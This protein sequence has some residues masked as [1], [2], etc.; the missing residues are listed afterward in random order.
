MSPWGGHSV[1]PNIY[2]DMRHPYKYRKAVNITYVFTYLLDLSMAVAG[3]LMFGDGVR[4]EVTSNI[5][6][7]DG[8]PQVISVF[9][10]VCVAIIPLTKIPL[11]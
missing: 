3:L 1:F 8:Y 10:V 5:L 9:I 11:K 6:L 7:T 4:D 2:R